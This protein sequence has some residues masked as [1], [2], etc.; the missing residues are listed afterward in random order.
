MQEDK[1]SVVFHA[2][3]DPGCIYHEISDCHA[4]IEMKKGIFVST[5][6]TVSV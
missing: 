2:Q 3:E 4:H 6:I 1:I 5:Q